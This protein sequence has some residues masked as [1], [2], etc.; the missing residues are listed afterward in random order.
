MGPPHVQA[1]SASS[2]TLKPETPSRCGESIADGIDPATSTG[3]RMLNMLAT[4]AECERE[5]IV[6]RV[7]AG[8]AVARH[9][10]T[11]FGRPASDT[12]VIGQKLAIVTQARTAGKTAQQAAGLV[13][14]SRATLYRHQ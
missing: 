12:V 1:C 9:S 14:W 3:R 7:D 2:T 8:I 5:L 11:R 13:G 10:G 6:E 4:L